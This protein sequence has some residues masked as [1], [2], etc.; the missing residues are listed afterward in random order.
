MV[1]VMDVSL[2]HQVLA[3][4]EVTRRDAG[5]LDTVGRPFLLVQKVANVLIVPEHIL[6]VG[7][8]K[9]SCH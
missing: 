3:W 4:K 7:D 9:E 6:E 8:T 1:E 5:Q 2:P